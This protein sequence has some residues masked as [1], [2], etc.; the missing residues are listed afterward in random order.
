MIKPHGQEKGVVMFICHPGGKHQVSIFVEI[1]QYGVPNQK[2]CK[3]KKNIKFPMIPSEH[4]H[5]P[6][7][8][9]R[10]LKVQFS[11]CTKRGIVGCCFLVSTWRLTFQFPFSPY[12][13]DP[14]E[15]SNHLYHTIVWSYTLLAR[16]TAFECVLNLIH[17]GNVTILDLLAQKNYINKI[18]AIT[19]ANQK[20]PQLSCK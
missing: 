18:Q 19:H 11:A 1:Q 14:A 17:L 10:K 6:F 13:F 3:S 15:I 2:Y 20:I 16:C 4:A 8:M 9:A 12:G 5:I 7:G